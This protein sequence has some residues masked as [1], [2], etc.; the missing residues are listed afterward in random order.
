MSRASPA[1][2]AASA[3]PAPAAPAS[4]ASPEPS[5]REV[6]LKLV[7][8]VLGPVGAILFGIVAIVLFIMSGTH[9][10]SNLT[11]P[12]K[13][14][15]LPLMGMGLLYVVAL[16]YFLQDEA[17]AMYTVFALTVFTLAFAYSAIAVSAISN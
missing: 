10:T 6:V 11:N 4:L 14:I 2:N 13:Y 9:V 1:S 3:A 8:V 15:F 12:G 7:D 17:K 16:L 5:F